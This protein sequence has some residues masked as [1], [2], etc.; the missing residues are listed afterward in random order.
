MEISELQK[1]ISEAILSRLD[2]KNVEPSVELSMLH[3]IEEV[4]ELSKQIVNEKLKRKEIDVA[5]IGEEISDCIIML[6]FLAKQFNLNIE[7]CLINKI[8]ELKKK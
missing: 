2:K 6:M 8:E 5:N 1:K 3:L 4:G 7:K